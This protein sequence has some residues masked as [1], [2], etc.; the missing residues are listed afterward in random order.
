[1]TCLFSFF[2]TPTS[3]LF[4]DF[5]KQEVSFNSSV[6][7]YYYQRRLERAVSSVS[8]NLNGTARVTKMLYGI[9][10]TRSFVFVLRVCFSNYRFTYQVLV[11]DF[12]VPD[13]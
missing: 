10:C 1:M 12:L 3:L 11:L 2:T 9:V 8:Q 13:C 7:I 4:T 6:S 5:N